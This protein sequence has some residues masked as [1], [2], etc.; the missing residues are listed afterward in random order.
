[1]HSVQNNIAYQVHIISRSKEYKYIFSTQILLHHAINQLHEMDFIAAN[2]QNKCVSILPS[3]QVIEKYF[4]PIN[5]REE[6]RLSFE[7]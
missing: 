1:M 7:L 5:H 4:D 3:E 6:N 2:F